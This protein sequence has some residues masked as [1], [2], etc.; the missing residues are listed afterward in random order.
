MATTAPR[1]AGTRE[2]TGLVVLALPTLILAMDNSVLFLALPHL[3][4]D[5]E[6]SSTQMLW[7][8]DIYSFLVAGFLI[9]MGALGDR[10]GRRRLLMIG[11]FVFG[12]ASVLAA[13]ST[14]AEMLIVTRALLGI[15]GATLM[16]ST[17][18]LIRN[19]FPDPE[20]RTAAIGV[21]MGCFIIGV[22][23]GPIVGGSLLEFFWWGS[24]FLVAVPVMLILL[25]LG[26]PLLPEYRNPEAGRL[27]VPSVALSLAAVLPVIYALKEIAKDGFAWI[28]ALC[29]VAGLASGALFVRRQ[30]RIADPLIDLGLFKSR[31]FSSSLLVMTLSM[32]VMGGTYYFFTQYLQL[33][34]GLSALRTGLWLLPVA[35]VMMLG[36]G[37]VP[38]LA[39]TVRPGRLAG[40]G[41]LLSSVGLV[42]LAQVETD[43][44]RVLPVTAF[45]IVMAGL[46]PMMILGTDMI[47]GI[48]PPE[49]S[50]SASALSETGGEFG[51]ALGLAALGTSGNLV[52]RD[53]LN[54]T[55]PSA[56]PPEA[57]DAL[58]D[59]LAGA[60]AVAEE[61]PGPLGGE[62]AN[63]ARAAFVSG[64]QVSALIGAAV[65]ALSG[66]LALALLRRVPLVAELG[67]DATAPDA[68]TRQDDPAGL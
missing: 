36:A 68:D 19:M 7:I 33:V 38:Q 39:R 14:S 18:S 21:W 59:T 5:L 63:A 13:Y 26:R 57:L 12:V 15:A 23:L 27:D 1:K 9:T 50:G 34:D 44:S 32:C 11:A 42:V 6:P 65:V 29:V 10:I 53:E 35:A 41:L 45:L 17:L 24:A 22:V 47:V 31:A 54:D 56:T 51:I 48:A 40:A 60:L 49:K 37:V 43:S 25:V 66:V 46:T 67:G 28:P 20:Q 2:W 4:E 64:M 58:R 61:L 62:V 52:Y 55:L 3:A 8:M 30:G 16:P